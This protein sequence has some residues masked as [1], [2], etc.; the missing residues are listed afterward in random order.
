[1]TKELTNNYLDGISYIYLFFNDLLLDS[2][3]NHMYSLIFNSHSAY[4]YEKDVS[5]I[6]Y[7]RAW[8][9]G[10]S[11]PKK[12]SH[13]LFREL[14]YLKDSA[15]FYSIISLMHWKSISIHIQ[16]RTLLSL[17]TKLWKFCLR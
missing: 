17:I 12:I 14:K 11:I 3:N 13:L 1:M 7:R 10:V 16:S 9:V 5:C 15:L 6:Y 8:S 2:L 4:K